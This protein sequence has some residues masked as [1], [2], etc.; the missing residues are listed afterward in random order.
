M[1]DDANREV[2]VYVRRIGKAFGAGL[3]AMLSLFITVFGSSYMMN[4]L[5]YHGSVM[6]VIAGIIGAVPP[7]SIFV[8]IYAAYVRI[9]NKEKIPYFGL[10][11]L[12]SGLPPVPVGGEEEEAGWGTQIWRWIISPFTQPFAWIYDRGA[13]EEALGGLMAATG[14]EVVDESLIAGAQ[15]AARLPKAAAAE[16]AR[17]ALVRPAASV[18]PPETE[19]PAN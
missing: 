17:D 9:K 11:P 2:V 6:R 15:A 14:Q 18:P 8:I 5:I 3:A 1:S 12:G 16:A 10:F 7:L 19:A 4:R 13:Y